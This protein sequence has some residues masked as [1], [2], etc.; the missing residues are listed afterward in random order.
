MS[1]V[2]PIRPLQL[3]VYESDISNPPTPPEGAHCT[4]VRDEATGQII[5]WGWT[6]PIVPREVLADRSWAW[7]ERLSSIFAK[8]PS[9]SDVG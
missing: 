1:D 3:C 7:A 9:A 2:R 6:H 5:T 4:E 8:R